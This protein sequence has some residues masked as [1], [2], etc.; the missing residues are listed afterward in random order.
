MLKSLVI[1][2]LVSILV[3]CVF[4][5]LFLPSPWVLLGAFLIVVMLE[6]VDKYFGDS[7]YRRKIYISIYVS[8][9]TFVA[10]PHFSQ[11]IRAVLPNYVQ[12]LYI[13]GRQIDEGL[14]TDRKLTNYLVEQAILD[15]KRIQGELNKFTA[16]RKKRRLTQSEEKQEEKFVQEMRD[17]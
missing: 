17:V 3:S 16:I 12:T 4:W 11:T 14:A 13:A 7:P 10:L 9:W 6:L 1:K 2:L 8:L 5:F 15:K